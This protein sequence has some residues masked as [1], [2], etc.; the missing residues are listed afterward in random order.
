M[1]FDHGVDCFAAGVLPLIFSRILQ[2]GD[3]MIAKIF[4]FAIYQ[5]FYLA[6][7][8]HYYLG[9]LILPPINGVSDGCVFV[10]PFCIYTAYVGNNFWATPVVDGRWL[11]IEGVEDL[12]YGQ[13]MALG[14]AFSVSCVA[15]YT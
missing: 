8:E 1:V 2:V 9:R 12:T 10:T 7:L 3:N 14:I 4:F 13:L 15:L 11:K 5:A 6:T